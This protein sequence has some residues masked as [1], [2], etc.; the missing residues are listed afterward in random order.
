MN[1]VPLVGVKNGWVNSK[2]VYKINTKISLLKA[3]TRAEHSAEL[4][5]AEANLGSKRTVPATSTRESMETKK[6]KS[7][8]AS[9]PKKMAEQ[10]SHFRFSGS[11]KRKFRLPKRGEPAEGMC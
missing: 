8:V 9:L 5:M 11:S 6:R 1:K 10:M 2:H 7:L 3:S 4:E